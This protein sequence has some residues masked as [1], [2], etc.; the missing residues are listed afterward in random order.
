[1]K[2]IIMTLI[3]SLTLF[4]NQSFAYILNYSFL[5]DTAGAYFTDKDWQIFQK[6]QLYVLN[7]GRDGAMRHW[8]NPET[9]SWGTFVPSHTAMRKGMRCRDLTIVNASNFRIGRSTLTFCKVN[10]EWKGV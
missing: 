10:G 4:I 2:T 7:N 9:G 1:M 6:N 3:L 5:D 8:K